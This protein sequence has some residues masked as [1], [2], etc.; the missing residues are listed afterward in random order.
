MKPIE[1]YNYN[2]EMM[3]AVVEGDIATVKNHINEG[4]SIN[5]RAE[6]GITPLM[7]ASIYGQYDI[8][9]FLIKNG[10]KINSRDD[11]GLT[12]LICACMKG[13]TKIVKLLIDNGAWLNIKY[14]KN[15]CTALIVA[16]QYG[17]KDIINLLIKNGASTAKHSEISKK[18]YNFIKKEYS[19][20]L[21]IKLK[22]RT[23]KRDDELYDRQEDDPEKGLIIKNIKTE[24]NK[25]YDDIEYERGMCHKIWGEIKKRLKEEHGIDWLTPQEANPGTCYD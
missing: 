22:E 15:R 3:R 11:V 14:S 19:E 18:Y 4:E 21:A 13:Y 23:F 10:A 20:E 17:F 12:A 25:K 8:V 16:K 2:I 7:A 5:T 24:I 9:K 1:N 6:G